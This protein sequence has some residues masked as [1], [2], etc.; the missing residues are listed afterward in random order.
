M[1][2]LVVFLNDAFPKNLDISN[3]DIV[4]LG[5]KGYIGFNLCLFL[6]Q[7]NITYQALDT[8]KD[9]LDELDHINNL[10]LIDCSRISKFDHQTLIKD[11][12]S[13]EKTLSA[14]SKRKGFYFRIGSILEINQ[15]IE[16]DDYISWSQNKTRLTESFGADLKYLTMFIPNIYGGQ[17]S[18]SI[19]DKMKSEFLSGRK[20]ALSNPENYRDF[21][22]LQRFFQPLNDLLSMIQNN[23][24]TRVALTSGIAYQVGSIQQFIHDGNSRDLKSISAEYSDIDRCITM[25][26][27]L[28]SYFQ[29]PELYTLSY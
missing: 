22:H 12:S 26:D 24:D 17:K 11:N 13:H 5:S 7:S 3:H 6:Q 14:L 25:P 20:L 8:R 9:N 29:N 4:V 18:T 28:K 16:K 15:N 21:L 23:S 1:E 2:S 19:V 10:L 27:D